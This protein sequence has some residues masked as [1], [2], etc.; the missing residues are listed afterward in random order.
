MRFRCVTSETQD[1]GTHPP[2]AK[3]PAPTR[4]IALV[5]CGP[6]SAGAMA[7]IELLYKDCTQV[8]T[9]PGAMALDDLGA[10]RP[11]RMRAPS[12]TAN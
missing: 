9:V 7:A 8:T 5:Q 2:A 6:I 11:S 12:A 1:P 3:A 4:V 10:I